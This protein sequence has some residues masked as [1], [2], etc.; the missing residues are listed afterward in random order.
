[1]NSRQ[2]YRNISFGI[3]FVLGLK[4]ELGA[5]NLMNKIITQSPNNRLHLM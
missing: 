1:M 4:T 2:L 3:D 5:H